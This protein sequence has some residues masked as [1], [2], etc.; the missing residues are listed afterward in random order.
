MLR[1]AAFVR[2]SAIAGFLRAVAVIATALMSRSYIPRPGISV[3]LRNEL[4]LGER[5]AHAFHCTWRGWARRKKPHRCVQCG[6]PSCRMG[7][8]G[9][10][11]RGLHADGT[12]NNN[13][14]APCATNLHD[15]RRAPGLG[16]R[17]AKL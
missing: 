13:G 9:F 2:R 1:V 5:F 12:K 8:L 7:G 17:R 6:T 11:P 14:A 4:L 15:Q 3:H 10:L 16:R